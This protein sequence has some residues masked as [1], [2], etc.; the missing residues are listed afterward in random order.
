MKNRKLSARAV[1]SLMLSAIL[2]CMPIGA[3]FANR[4]NTIEVHAEDTAEQKTESA[5]E[6][7]SA[8]ST[9][10]GNDN[11]GSS[12]SDSGENN[13]ENTTE[14]STEGTTEE[15]QP[16]AKCTCKEKCSQYAV[17]EDC[18]VCAKDYKEC[19]YINPSVKITINTP[20]GWHNDTTKVTVKVEDTIVSGNFTIQ[21]VKA[22]VGQNGSW[23]DITEDMYIEISENS[24][25]YVQVTDQKG[26][27][28]EKNRYI[29][30][31]DFTKPTLNAAVSDGLL[32]IQ[33]HDTDS[34][35]KAIYVNGYEFTEHTNGALN[36]R[37][38][39]FDAGYQYFTI[40]AMDNAGNTSEI[41]KTANPYYSDPENKDS[42]EKDP[43][44]QLPVDASAT[45][46][47][48]ATA[49]VTEHTKTDVNGNTVSQTGSG[50]ASRSTG[51]SA[52]QSPSTGDTSKDTDQSSDS[53]TSEKGKE[54]YTIQTA[55]EKVFYLVIDR[56][57]EDEKVYF[58]TEV[59]ENDL[60]NTT[61]DNSETLPKNS[62][63]L[64][65]A[66]PTKDSALSNNNAD[67]T[68]DKTQGTESVE[69][70]NE[71]STEDTSDPK[72]DTAKADGSSFTYILMGIAAVA[73]IGV[74]YVVKSKKKKE[75][76][77][78]EDEDED[79]LDEDYDYEDEDEAEQDSDEAFLNGGDDTVSDAESEDTGENDSE[80]NSDND[81]D[82]ENGEE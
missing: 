52:K 34:G 21:T 71:E 17:D 61:T 77:I 70:S 42:S 39:Q 41:Y 22:K 74:V 11:K 23:T 63:A 60:L 81:N 54:F 55:S 12:D 68:G 67:T 57:G 25:I 62:A 51:T 40:S 29:K 66:I 50:T 7:S 65:S 18:A 3:F 20:S 45:K 79:E 19:A 59:S 48:S 9:T 4:T 47:S 10:S 31:F 27:T 73:V 30:C 53:Q 28:Y 80:D 78:D 16:A 49:Q 14:N 24:T 76:F 35:I 32:S 33:A 58:L 26:K 75:N 82:E 37:L 13:T 56:D 5:A 36:I 2:F 46:P 38:Q 43:A 15:T 64:E 6:E 1:V 72:E 69:D 44:Q 8:E